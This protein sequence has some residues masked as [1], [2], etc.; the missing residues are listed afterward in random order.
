MRSRPLLKQRMDNTYLKLQMENGTQNSQH[1]KVQ[2]EF[3]AEGLEGTTKV[4][5]KVKLPSGVDNGR[6]GTYNTG[7]STLIVNVAD[8]KNV[9][10]ASIYFAPNGDTVSMRLVGANAED[11][12]DEIVQIGTAAAN[13]WIDLE[14]TID[15]AENNILCHSKRRR[16]SIL[17]IIRRSSVQ[18]LS[19][20]NMPNYTGIPRYVNVYQERNGK[21]GL[22]YVD[23]VV[24]DHYQPQRELFERY[25][26]YDEA[27]VDTY[28][29]FDVTEAM[30]ETADLHLSIYDDAAA[31]ITVQYDSK[32][33]EKEATITTE[34]TGGL[35]EK[36]LRFG[37]RCI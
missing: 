9:D 21:N 12:E 17:H 24:V 18:K 6:G 31:T 3:S 22:G 34:G 30:H 15:Q 2:K 27:E 4:S 10:I 14:I 19:K 32:T 33:G 16:K 1:Q 5:M 7:G 23:D 26:D 20:A 8:T 11:G 28:V 35:V 29:G 13:V 37:R 36:K 25:D